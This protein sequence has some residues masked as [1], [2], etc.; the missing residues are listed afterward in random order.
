MARELASP[1][2]RLAILAT[3]LAG[4]LVYAEDKEEL[5]KQ[6]QNPII[7]EKPD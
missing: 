1:L 4:R 6:A 7:A 3:L 2:F 5:A